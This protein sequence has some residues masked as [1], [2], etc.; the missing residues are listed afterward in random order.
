M[1]K[2]NGRVMYVFQTWFVFYDTNYVMWQW[3]DNNGFKSENKTKKNC[4]HRLFFL[5]Q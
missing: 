3:N 5:N 2:K 1:N 4:F